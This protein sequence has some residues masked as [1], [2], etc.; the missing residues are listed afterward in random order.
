MMTHFVFTSYY[1]LWYII[2]IFESQTA[3]LMTLN[4]VWIDYYL[5]IKSPRIGLCL[6]YFGTVFYYPPLPSPLYDLKKPDIQTWCWFNKG[7]QSLPSFRLKSE[8]LLSPGL[9]C[10]SQRMT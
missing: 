8:S 7:S 6:Q 9:K 3:V 4:S 2:E 10:I 5:S 1:K